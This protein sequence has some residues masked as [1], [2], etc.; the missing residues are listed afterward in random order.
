MNNPRFVA[1]RALMEI[2][3]GG[4]SSQVLERFLRK[5]KPRDRAFVTELVMGVLRWRG[6]LDYAVA[7]LSN[8][9]LEKIEPYVMNALRMGIYQMERMRVADYAAVKETVALLKAQWK[10][11]FVNGILRSFAREG[12]RYPGK[13]TPLMYL[14]HTLSTP[15]WKALRWLEE[16]GLEKAEALALYYNSPPPIYLRVNRKKISPEELALRLKREGVQ[17]E[18]CPE[19]PFCLKVKQGNPK[20]TKTLREGLFYIQDKA[21]QVAGLIASTLGDEVWDPCTAPGGKASHM[22][23]LG[24]KVLASDISFPRLKL[25]LS[26]FKRL[27]LKIRV[28]VADGKKPALRKRFPLVLLDAPCSSMGIIH[29]APEVKWRI[30]PEALLSLSELQSQLLRSLLPYGEKLL[31]V[32]CTQEREETEGVVEDYGTVPLTAP[33]QGPFLRKKDNF[34]LTEPHLFQSDGMFYALVRQK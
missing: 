16:F 25:A 12:V 17:T 24:K 21:S 4:N 15:E 29:R 9:R 7:Y 34:L 30:T 32:V 27:G 33:L 28:F 11:S 23:E 5:L 19:L 8:I 13:E 26:N 20:L 31:Y 1:L 22:A 14:T 10:R 18:E 3:A 6:R 2:E